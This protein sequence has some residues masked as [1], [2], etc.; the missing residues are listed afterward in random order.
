MTLTWRQVREVASAERLQDAFRA[1][2]ALVKEIAEGFTTTQGRRNHA[3]YTM[4]FS[5]V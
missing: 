5:L 2:R 4:E 3:L 1:V